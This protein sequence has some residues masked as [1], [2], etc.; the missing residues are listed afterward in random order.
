MSS[1]LLE[2]LSHVGSAIV[3]PLFTSF[4]VELLVCAGLFVWRRNRRPLFVA[5]VMLSVIVC[6][7]AA[8]LTYVTVRFPTYVRLYRE[9]PELLTS[10][11]QH[12]PVLQRCLYAVPT[13]L[14]F[15]MLYA[16]CY[17]AIH[18]CFRIKTSTAL[19][20]TA[21]A[22]A[23]QHF[24]HC[25]SQIIVDMMPGEWGDVDQW[26][27]AL[28]LFLLSVV[29]EMAGY[30]MFVRPL[31]VI[32]EGL[33]GHG[34]LLLFAGLMLCVNVFA[35]LLSTFP[36]LPH[37]VS[38]LMMLTRLVTCAFVLA[39]LAVIAGR[40]SAE[41]DGAVLRGLLSQQQAQL[42]S[43]KETI[44]L[45]NIKTHDLKKQLTLLS[46][47]ISQDEIAELNHLVDIYD[48]SI[49][50]GNEALD[51]VLANKSLL[52]E[53]KGIRFER[54]VDGSQ[55]VA[56]KPADIYAL[57]GNAIDN[58]IEAVQFIKE[59]E[60]RYVELNVRE[61]MGMVRIHIENPYDAE[62]TFDD[63]LPRTTKSDRQ[64]HGF[65]LR[66]MRMIAKQ[67]KGVL[68]VSAEGGVFAVDVLLPLS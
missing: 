11:M 17:A 15:M 21:A 7:A 52:C 55:L 26:Q 43:D 44:D 54:M 59:S 23:M 25:A 39:L 47:R 29:C 42:A 12:M 16:L 49:R 32:P 46:G 13:I 40:E 37:A 8:V 64:Y 3:L 35:C 27:G 18:F 61:H 22:V 63:G 20:Y 24:V 19:F 45:I 28:V 51:V 62:L 6:V 56:M 66:S 65:G 68:T 57:F 38:V 2:G 60:R 53:Q 41:R 5:R 34:V 9:S 4:I 33:T 67:Y 30:W 48:A 1:E 58:A 31:A 36:L 10:V 50:T 14:R